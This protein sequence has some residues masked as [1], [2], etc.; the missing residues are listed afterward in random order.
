MAHEANSRNEKSA[1]L[2]A[3]LL[4]ARGDVASARMILHAVLDQSPTYG[5]AKRLIA[6]IDV[7][8]KT[9][10]SDQTHDELRQQSAD[11]EHERR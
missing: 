8:A 4:V 2:F 11:D 5:P 3:R 6:T 10:A 9:L 1:T 7:S